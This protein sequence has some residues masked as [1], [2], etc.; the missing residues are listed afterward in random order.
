MD[1]IVIKWLGH[2]CYRLE[3]DGYS[4]VVDPY[5]FGSVPGL[6]RLSV[7]ANEVYCSHG[8]DDHGYRQAVQLAPKEGLPFT[9]T[10]L[11][12][13]HDEVQGAKRGP[14]TIHI[15]EAHGIR[16]AHLGDLGCALTREQ[17][18][19]LTGVDALLIPVGG[20]YTIDAKAAWELIQLLNPVV[21]IPMHYRTDRL[22]YDVIDR[23]EV[24]L[25]LCG[26]AEYRTEDTISIEKG[27]T[28]R[29]TVLT[30]QG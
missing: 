8:H 14:N 28:P 19:L 24:F 11:D 4:I 10:K 12:S 7:R 23:L 16:V 18:Q 22:G 17:Q 6:S 29:V 9:V 1:K 13:F 3:S 25:D 21:A 26:H 20:Y 2:S 30:Y 27:M 15:F 5:K